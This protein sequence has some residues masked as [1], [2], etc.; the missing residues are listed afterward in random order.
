MK[1]KKNLRQMLKSDQGLSLAEVLVAVGLTGLLA[2]G[3]TQLALASFTSANYTQSIA[4]KSLNSGN[5]N[6]LVTTD[7][8]NASGFL[9]PGKSAQSLSSGVCTSADSSSFAS[10][11][12][13]PLVVIQYSSG[14][15][16]G[17]E[18]RSDNGSGSLWRVSCP[19]GG[20]ASG[21]ESMIRNLLPTGDSPVWDSSVTCASFPIGG[22]L[23]TANC[24]TDTWLTS[25]SVNPGIVFTIPSTLPGKS[26]SVVA[27]SIVA[28]RNSG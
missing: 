23:Q 28:A 13:N 27:Q 21:P 9:I 10:G 12:V 26:V 5:E 15:E 14:S 25:S 3:C 24:S 22:T 6:L 8:E 2:L 4:L 7:M 1:Y 17:Y 20:S 18:I 11:A 19:T 16:I